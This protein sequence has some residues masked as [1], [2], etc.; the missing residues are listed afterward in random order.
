MRIAICS[1]DTKDVNIIQRHIKDIFRK[2][3][4]NWEIVIDVY[5]NTFS[6][7]DKM[8]THKIKYDIYIIAL[9][10]D[11]AKDIDIS[12]KI[13]EKQSDVKLVYMVD[14][15][16]C[17]EYMED[18]VDIRPH[19]V[20]FKPIT[21]SGVEKMVNKVVD[22]MTENEGV[23]TLKN[24]EGI[25]TVTNN[26]I[27]Y[28]ESESRY[29]IV[30]RE[31]REPIK[32]I[33]TFEKIEDKLNEDFV[34]CHRCYYVNCRKIRKL[35]KKMIELINDKTIPVSVSNYNNVYNRYLEIFER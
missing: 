7:F 34:K 11:G 17:I 4:I 5:V 25:Y 32:I 16:S 30:N 18:I 6:M 3:K 2:K 13:F 9:Y 26:E 15:N 31:N 10:K 22:M 19:A 24:K 35:N 29:L 1:D 28:I 8:E 12:R 23:M 21:K 27:T 33:S 20:L 14:A